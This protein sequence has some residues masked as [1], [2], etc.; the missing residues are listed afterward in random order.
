MR[1]GLADVDVEHGDRTRI[2]YRN[3]HPERKERSKIHPHSHLDEAL[4]CVVV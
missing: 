1:S 2:K 4:R 3:R